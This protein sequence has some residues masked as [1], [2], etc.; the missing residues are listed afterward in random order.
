M[1]WAKWLREEV[2]APVPHR[3]V[4]LDVDGYFE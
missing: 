2:L 4:I 3:H 1:L